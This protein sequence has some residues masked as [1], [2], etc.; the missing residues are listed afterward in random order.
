MCLCDAKISQCVGAVSSPLSCNERGCAMVQADSAGASPHQVAWGFVI[1]PYPAP[2]FADQ[3]DKACC[4]SRCRLSLLGPLPIR[5]T[6]VLSHGGLAFSACTSKYTVGNLHVASFAEYWLQGYCPCR[7]AD[8][9]AY[10]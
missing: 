7:S 4:L 10:V 2:C 3:V 8:I 6:A 5:L 9:P 1:V